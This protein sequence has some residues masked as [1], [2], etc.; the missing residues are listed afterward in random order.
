MGGMWSEVRGA[1]KIETY[2]RYVEECLLDPAHLVN[3]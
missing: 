2:F 3:S 1:T